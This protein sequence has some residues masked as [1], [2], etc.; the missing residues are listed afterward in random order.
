MVSEI[1][2]KLSLP[3]F[4][5]A[6]AGHRTCRI[7]LFIFVILLFNAPLLIK[8]YTDL[9]NPYI[10]NTVDSQQMVPFYKFYFKNFST[11]YAHEYY[12]NA[13]AP[14]GYKY[15][16]TSLSR[17]FNPRAI[18]HV[19]GAGLILVNLIF[20]YL[21][22]KKF[23]GFYT[24]LATCLILITSELVNY[25]TISG[26]PHSF[27][28]P[29]LSAAMYFFLSRKLKMG[30]LTS[31][32]G[33]CFYPMIGLFTFL[34]FFVR[35]YFLPPLFLK[36]R[37]IFSRKTVY[38]IITGLAAITVCL[39]MIIHGQ[40]YGPRLTVDSTT[41]FPEFGEQGRYY[42]W[43]GDQPPTYANIQ[44]SFFAAFILSLTSHTQGDWSKNKLFTPLIS[45]AIMAVF[46]LIIN[47]LFRRCRRRDQPACGSHCVFLLAYF[48]SLSLCLLAS[49]VF[50]PYL[51][52]PERYIRHTLPV[53]FIF[54]LCP[55]IA[56]ALEIITFGKVSKNIIFPAVMLY[57][58]LYNISSNGLNYTTHI[59]DY[60]Q[61][62]NKA[63][64]EFISTLPATSQLV[65]WPDLRYVANDVELITHRKVYYSIE[66]HQVAHLAPTLIMR[67]MAEKFFD[68][69]FATNIDALKKFR[70]ETGTNYMIVD[71]RHFLSPDNP[72]YL[73]PTYFAP[74][75]PYIDTKLQTKKPF[76]L[77]QL[78]KQAVF[79]NDTVFI[80]NLDNLK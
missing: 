19:V 73:K 24:A 27:A 76:I 18:A 49:T 46:L 59:A 29:V 23:F 70:D 80:V 36:K 37:E 72:D 78:E 77:P 4:F 39:P 14:L 67:G 48:I 30:L 54:Y 45:L 22:G 75:Q 53:V 38:F 11:S 52:Y 17:F 8:Y 2:K 56:R 63:V 69:Y 5:G 66:K 50:F 55:L 79:A 62:K 74:F 42:T 57:A 33:F 6:I 65:G 31:F 20:V 71:K 10:I 21:A 25:L 64:Y 35:E 34:M 9:T 3:D 44:K 40:S 68:A 1:N 12:L 15:L 41:Q 51:F 28:F 43:A 47:N 13:W 58:L 7:A 26:V 16:Y 32:L 60:D 61:A